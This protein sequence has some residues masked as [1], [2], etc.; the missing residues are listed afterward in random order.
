VPNPPVMICPQDRELDPM[1]IQQG[2]FWGVPPEMVKHSYL[3]NIYL[4]TGEIKFGKTKG[5][6]ATEIIVMGEKK[7][8]YSDFHMDPGQFDTIVE[9]YRHGLYVGSNYLFM[10]GHVEPQLPMIAKKGL[11]PWNPEPVPPP[12]PTP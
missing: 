12:P 7:S 9:Q 10:D 5:I 1:D 11:E 6:S 3:L 8:G 2:Q 4:Q